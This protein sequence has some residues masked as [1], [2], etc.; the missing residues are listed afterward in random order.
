MANVDKHGEFADTLTHEFAHQFEQSIPGLM[1]LETWHFIKRLRAEAKRTQKL[2]TWEWD[3]QRFGFVD[4]FGDQ[5]MGRVYRNPHTGVTGVTSMGGSE[6]FSTASQTLW[7]NEERNAADLDPQARRLF[8]GVMAT[9]E[10][11][12]LDPDERWRP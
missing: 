7:A 11:P 3:D 6:I 1:L 2:A 12:G 10:P 5:Y 9:I 8:M 4:E